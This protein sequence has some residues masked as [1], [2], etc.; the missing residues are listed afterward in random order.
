MIDAREKIVRIIAVDK[1]Y[2][3]QPYPAIAIWD[4]SKLCYL[5]GQHIDPAIPKTRSNLTV[6]EMTGKKM[7]SEEKMAKFPYIINPENNIP[8]IHMRKLNISIDEKGEPVNHVDMAMYIFI[9]HYCSFVADSKKA[10]RPGTDFFYIEDLESEAEEQIKS[11][12]LR[13]EAEKCIR[14]KASIEKLK[15]TALMLNYTIKNFSMPVDSMTETRIKNEL[16]K[17]C[18]K[19][20]DKIIACFKAQANEELYIYKLVKHGILEQKNGAFFDGAQIIGTN[21]DNV[22]IYMK[23]S[24][25]ENQ[26]YVSKWGKLLLEKEGKLPTPPNTDKTDEPV[27]KLPEFQ[28]KEEEVAYITN[29][30]FDILKKYAGGGKRYKGVDWKELEE[31]ALRTF[32]IEKLQDKK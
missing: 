8:I 15:D 16:L 32:L 11:S 20:P 31:E 3:K 10:V 28:D 17:V 19:N 5:T 26:K 4:N 22:K 6:D 27:Y 29:S 23:S 14:E 25:Q 13:F 24:N 7:P 30:T 18:E 1:R 12:D 21:V 9:K 2:V